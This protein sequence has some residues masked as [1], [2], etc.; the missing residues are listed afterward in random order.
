[1]D[2]M[3]QQRIKRVIGTVEI[4]FHKNGRPR[5]MNFARAEYFEQ[6]DLNPA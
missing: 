6:Y 1:M 5:K 3:R 4:T 2:K